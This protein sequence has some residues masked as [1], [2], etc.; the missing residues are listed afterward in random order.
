MIFVFLALLFHSFI[1]I[2]LTSFHFEREMAEPNSPNPP[3]PPQPAPTQSS[4]QQNQADDMALI[5]LMLEQMQQ[6]IAILKSKYA[7]NNEVT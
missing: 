5:K 2:I 1:K 4:V 6:D 3:N 7:S